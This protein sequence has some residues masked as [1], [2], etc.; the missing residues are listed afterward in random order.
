[1]KRCPKCGLEKKNE[2][3]YKDKRNSDGLCLYCKTCSNINSLKYHKTEKYKEYSRKYHDTPK[4]KKYNK[5]YLKNKRKNDPAFRLRSKMSSSIAK[6]ISI[7]TNNS[8]EEKVGYTL[9]A[10]M[11]HLEKQFKP[12]MN[13]N[14]YGKGKGKWNVDHI[15]PISS[16]KFKS[17]D[18]V[19][20]KKCWA[21][22]NLQPLEAIENIRKSNKY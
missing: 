18:D 21:L 10:L 14:N 4:W 11:S 13:W 8:W 17:S 1:M 12:W 22:N 7:K 9:E 5:D 19:E 6:D 16:F 20:F 3:F 2:E 15:K